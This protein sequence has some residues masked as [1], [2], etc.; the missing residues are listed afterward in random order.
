MPGEADS[1]I[2]A[3]FG[4]ALGVFVTKRPDAVLDTELKI[5]QAE[6]A[7]NYERVQP[8]P[9]IRSHITPDMGVEWSAQ[10][11][12][13]GYVAGKGYVYVM[14]RIAKVGPWFITLRSTSNPVELASTNINPMSPPDA[15]KSAANDIEA[16]ASYR[17]LMAVGSAAAHDRAMSK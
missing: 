14:R 4:A 10:K 15:L 16:M 2:V 3:G 1:C 7:A 17:F 13:L 11:S 9:E 8:G 5:L 6:V 12:Y